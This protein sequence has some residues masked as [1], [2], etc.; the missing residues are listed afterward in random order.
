ML[1]QSLIP[2]EECVPDT[3]SVQCQQNLL[4]RWR[5]MEPHVR[6]I[7][8]YVAGRVV[9]GK[10]ASGIYDYSQ[11]GHRSVDGTVTMD[12]VNVY[13]YGAHC[14][15]SGDGHE[16]R[17]GLYHFGDSS[18]VDLEVADHSFRGYDHGSGGQ[19]EGRVR[20]ASIELYDYEEGRYFS[21][22]I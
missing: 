10:S 20:G 8:A 12:R 9:S 1:H 21:Y 13:D 17:F 18:Y 22:S 15:F 2:A 14:F 3:F 7:V 19:F 5:T 16:G 6:A 11:R 4:I